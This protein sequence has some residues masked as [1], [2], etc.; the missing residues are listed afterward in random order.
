MRTLR[1]AL[2]HSS[3]DRAGFRSISDAKARPAAPDKFESESNRIK[4]SLSTHRALRD[5]N[6]AQLLRSK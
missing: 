5:E 3:I 1:S 4:N 6:A 2:D